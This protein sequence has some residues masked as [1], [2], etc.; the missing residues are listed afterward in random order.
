MPL[1]TRSESRPDS[2]SDRDAADATL[3][4]TPCSVVWSKGHAYVLEGL[5]A[6][7][8][9]VDDRGRPRAFTGT[10]LRRRGWSLGREA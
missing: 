4:T 2:V 3:P 8:V 9:G 6:C 5:R 1:E 7:W 10:D